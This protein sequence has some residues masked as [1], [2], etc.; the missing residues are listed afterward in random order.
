MSTTKSAD[1]VLAGYVEAMGVELGELFRATSNE[2]SWIHWRW[3][4]YRILFGERP[5]RI[6]LLNEAA[7]F[8]FHIVQDVFFEDTLLAIA[9][10]VAWPESYGQSN[11]TIR[12]FLP[13]IDDPNLRDKISKLID[14]AA[15][16]AAFAVDWRHRHL[17]HRDLDLA[18]NT[19]SQPLKLAT[20]EK[21][22]ESLSALRDVLNC[23]EGHYCDAH[24]LYSGPAVPGDADA[25]LYV[26]R[27]GL[28]RERDRHARWDRGERH[29][30]DVNPPGDV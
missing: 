14:R 26:I 11:L 7:P 19:S 22:E 4:Q 27:D 15:T 16:C 25:L 3:N 1:E 24:T 17:A 5:S 23:I 2:V 12:R 30:D 20:R 18:L 28:L 13:L 6:D 29:D 10:L 8:F 21:V 9:R